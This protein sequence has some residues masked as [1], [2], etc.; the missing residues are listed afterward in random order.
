MTG[1][2]GFIGSHLVDAL[3]AEGVGRLVVVDNL[4]LGKESNL[5][6]AR[7]AFPDLKF[8][9]EDAGDLQRMRE[10]MAYEK[11]EVVFNLAIVPLPA[12]LEKPLWTWRENVRITEAMCELARLGLY[13]TLIHCSSSEVYG[14]AVD[15]PMT[16]THPLLPRTPYAASKAA[17]DHLV[18][19]YVS[20]FKIDAAIIRPFNNYGPRQN[21]GTYAG[22]I[23]VVIKSM[24]S[25]GPV[26]IFGD[27]EQTRDYIYVTDA[28]AAAVDI[29]KCART[30]GRVLNIA[31]GVEVSINRL[32][33]TI[34]RILKYDGE[35]VHTSPRPGDVRQHWADISMARNLIGFSPR[36]GLR[37][38][39]EKTVEW[40]I[41][42]YAA[43]GADRKKGGG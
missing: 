9:R 34:A 22:V 19:S 24:L 20:T 15:T 17:C 14:S 28:A 36:V 31:S 18:L 41:K 3:V 11:V 42:N 26:T 8:Y 27:G 16:E 13:K 1:G 38:G 6:E 5:S 7:A 29:Y 33:D 4:F 12:S 25:G 30:R 35:I 39:L 37:E 43:W 40:Y 10:I 32:V 23:P 21:E 2:A